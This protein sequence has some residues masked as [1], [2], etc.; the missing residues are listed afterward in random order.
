MNASS[1][2]SFKRAI[3]GEVEDNVVAV[4][5]AVAD[6]WLTSNE[7]A[8]CTSLRASSAKLYC[9]RLAKIGVFEEVRALGGARYRV[10]R[11]AEQLHPELVGAIEQKRLAL[12]MA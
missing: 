2:H 1:N 8:V 6:C 9:T 3:S 4:Y 10:S 12:A 11:R 7:V 5:D